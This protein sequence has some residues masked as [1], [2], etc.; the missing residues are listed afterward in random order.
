MAKIAFNLEV[1]SVYEQGELNYHGEPVGFYDT[2]RIRGFNFLWVECVPGAIVQ[3]G[4]A[5]HSC[6]LPKV[7]DP[8]ISADID[9]SEGD[10]RELENAFNDARS[11][12]DHWDLDEI[13]LN[14]LLDYERSRGD[15]WRL[16]SDG[17]M[18]LIPPGR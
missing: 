18:T 6:P 9:L 16:L 8:E 15:G 4:Q 11:R 17:T 13:E 2:S 5:F 12:D 7:T 1:F 14:L 3:S 10:L